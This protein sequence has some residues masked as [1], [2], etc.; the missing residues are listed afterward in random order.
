V[1][2]DTLMRAAWHGLD[3]AESNLT[4]QMLSLRRGLAGVP[5]AAG[6]IETLARRGYRLVV[7]VAWHAPD[8]NQVVQ[9]S[10]S[11]RL[12]PPSIAVMPFITTTPALEI[13]ASRLGDDV[14]SMLAG[15]RE[16]TVVSNAA[17]RAAALRFTDPLEAGRALGVRY[18][19][20]AQVETRTGGVEAMIELFEIDNG[21]LLWSRGFPV[22][23]AACPRVTV[24][25]FVHIV[26]SIAPRVRE[27]ELRRIH[28]R[29]RDDLTVYHL[30]LQVPPRLASHQKTQVFE[31]REMID[32]ALAHDPSSSSAHELM[33]VW[34]DSMILHG[35]VADHED[36]IAE[37]ERHAMR[38][39]A[40]DGL[41][42][43]ALARAG[44]A[45]ARHRRD[46]AGARELLDRALDI[47]PNSPKAWELSSFVLSWIGDGDAA[48]LHGERAMQLSRFDPQMP[49]VLVALC[50]AHYTAGNFQMAVEFVSRSYA[51]L[52]RSGMFLIFGA[53]AAAALNK[54]DKASSFL[55]KLH[56]NQPLH[57]ATAFARAYPYREAWRRDALARHLVDAGLQT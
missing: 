10:G 44:H 51:L 40:L 27:I 7:P 16:I 18:L 38:A 57:G 1:T 12:L 53:A 3:M 31:A 54:S 55:A 52:P 26:H 2:K 15:L 8:E 29:R 22:E 46:Y 28:A 24:P 33:A 19:V 56:P 17:A 32:L 30:L 35:W 42:V 41:N 49:Q 23:D 21:A 6:W 13:L 48:T 47:G 50:L 43:T 45:R 34:Y 36:G 37:R 5:E 11:T 20:T 14:V 39:I 9:S 25:A 4:S